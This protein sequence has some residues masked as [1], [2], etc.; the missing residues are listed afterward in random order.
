MPIR[1]WGASFSTIYTKSWPEPGP[2]PNIPIE[3]EV[4]P[5]AATLGD[6]LLPVTVTAAG[7]AAIGYGISKIP[8]GGGENVSDVMGGWMYCACPK[9]F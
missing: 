8:V 2:E 5:E 9:C 3:V 4:A 6:L 7:G 1:W